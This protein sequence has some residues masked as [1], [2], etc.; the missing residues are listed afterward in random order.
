MP[1]AY[2]TDL[3]GRVLA[4][5]DEGMK[6]AEVMR[7]YRV[8]A[9]FFYTLRRL[10]QATGSIEPKEPSGGPKPVLREHL[11]ELRELV[12]KQPDATLE[13]LRQKLGISV[14]IPTVWRGLRDLGMTL[15]KSHSRRRAASA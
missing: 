2:S 8:S 1:T 10:R 6:P 3:R 14:S 15:K 5:H 11:G 7:R 4:A 9:N 12:R 13:E